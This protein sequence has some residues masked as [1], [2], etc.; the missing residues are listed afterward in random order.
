MAKPG[1]YTHW[2]FM[3]IQNE[4]QITKVKALGH[5]QLMWD[6]ST[7]NQRYRYKKEMIEKIAEWDGEKGKFVETLIKAG[8]IDEKDGECE[9]HD[10]LTHCPNWLRRKILY[11]EKR[12]EGVEKKESEKPVMRLLTTTN[13]FDLDKE[14]VKRLYRGLDGT[15][16][17]ENEEEYIEGIIEKIEDDEE[18]MG[19]VSEILKYIRDCRY[20]G[21]EKD[22]GKLKNEKA[23]FVSKIKELTK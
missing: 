19:E 15:I 18:K 12:K 4:L 21:K 9:L 16:D 1:L 7:I 8:F 23:F 3:M 13:V 2:K 10:F 22:L 14:K 17:Y 5:L 6:M 20:Y 11:E